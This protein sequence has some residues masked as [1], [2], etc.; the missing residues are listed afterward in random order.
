MARS[1][2]GRAR[3]HSHR[4]ALTP[5]QVQALID[6]AK[7]LLDQSED[8]QELLKALSGGLRTSPKAP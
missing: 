8:F 4:F 1:S 6:V 3:I 2:F 5:D 7:V